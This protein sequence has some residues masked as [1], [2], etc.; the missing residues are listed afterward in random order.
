MIKINNKK[1]LANINQS[2]VPEPR[3]LGAYSDKSTERNHS[4]TLWFVQSATSDA[5]KN[6]LDSSGTE[7]R[8]NAEGSKLCSLNT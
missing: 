3:R 6:F 8:F 7:R 2:I 5:P 4:I 1:K